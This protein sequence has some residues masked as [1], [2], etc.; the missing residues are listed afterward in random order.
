MFSFVLHFVEKF[1]DYG[2]S[3]SPRTLI[4]PTW[5]LYICA[6][7]RPILHVDFFSP[8][9]HS[10]ILCWRLHY[11]MWIVQLLR[12]LDSSLVISTSVILF[13]TTKG[14]SVPRLKPLIVIWN[15]V[16]GL[17]LSR[18]A[19]NCLFAWTIGPHFNSFDFLRVLIS[20]V[21][22]RDKCLK[23]EVWK[24]VLAVFLYMKC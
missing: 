7:L 2:S 3:S 24:L 1:S 4:I 23:F 5:S 15:L 14:F 13:T 16:I 9:F 6:P 12:F 10:T 18:K 20:W 8:Y 19:R 17:S 22:I 11:R 21:H